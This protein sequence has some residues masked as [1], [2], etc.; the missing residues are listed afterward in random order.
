MNAEKEARQYEII[1]TY[2]MYVKYTKSQNRNIWLRSIFSEV[3]LSV[4]NRRN[5]EH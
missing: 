2:K 3:T 5:V 1:R 4:Q